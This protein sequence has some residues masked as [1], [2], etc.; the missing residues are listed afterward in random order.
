MIFKII[1]IVIITLS[2]IPVGRIGFLPIAPANAIWYI[3]IIYAVLKFPYVLNKISEKG[4]L[5][6]AVYLLI[7]FVDALLYFIKGSSVEPLNLFAR[8]KVILL[9]ILTSLAV[10]N[11]HDL[12]FALKTIAVVIGISTF[13]GLLIHTFGEPFQSIRWFLISSPSAAMLGKGDRIAGLFSKVPSFAYQISSGAIIAYG[14]YVIEHKIKW[15]FVFAILFLGIIYNGERAAALVFFI[16]FIGILVMNKDKRFRKTAVSFGLLGII[17]AFAISIIDVQ[18]GVQYKSSESTIL[19][20]KSEEGEIRGK[21][22]QQLAGLVVFIKNPIIGG[23]DSDY[24]KEIRNIISYLFTN[25]VREPGDGTFAAPHNHYINTIMDNGIM[26][27]M[28]SVVFC[29]ILLRIIKKFRSLTINNDNLRKCYLVAFWALLGNLFVGVF[30]NLGIFIGEIS[31]WCIL[32]LV[33][34][35]STISSEQRL[36]E[37]R[38]SLEK[39]TEPLPSEEDVARAKTEKSIEILKGWLF[40]IQEKG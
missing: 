4:R 24:Q 19:H 30:H 14:L 9:F 32:S 6:I 10:N 31:G 2:F 1:Y 40:R 29:V 39:E 11:E 33:Y 36:N 35:G 12:K 25:K 28:L 5:I 20:R 38:T 3:F 16:A 15:L 23:T 26:G 37:L 27:F 18:E 21:I 8:F 13:F 34:A 17:I 22:A 7:I